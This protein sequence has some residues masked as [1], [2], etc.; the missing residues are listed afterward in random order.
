MAY[1]ADIAEETAVANI[2]DIEIYSGVYS[3]LLQTAYR[4]RVAVAALSYL[5]SLDFNGI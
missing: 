5:Y 4:V 3:R 2:T 1:H